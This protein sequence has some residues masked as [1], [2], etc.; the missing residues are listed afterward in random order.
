M[1][2]QEYLRRLNCSIAAILIA[3]GAAGRVSASGDLQALLE[4]AVAASYR[5]PV[6]ARRLDAELRTLLRDAPIPRSRR[7]RTSMIAAR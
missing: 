3:V 6:E 4:Q 5:S 7:A 1:R 2:W